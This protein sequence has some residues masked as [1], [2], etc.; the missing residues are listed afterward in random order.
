MELLAKN[1]AKLKKKPWHIHE[2]E[3]PVK[4]FCDGLHRTMTKVALMV[5]KKDK[6]HYQG[7]YGWNWIIANGNYSENEE[8]IKEFGGR[9]IQETKND[10]KI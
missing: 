4:D 3:C 10:V 2:N 5:G 8:F 1:K 7:T 9:L 6:N